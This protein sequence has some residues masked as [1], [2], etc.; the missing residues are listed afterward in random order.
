[1]HSDVSLFHICIDPLFDPLIILLPD[2]FLTTHIFILFN[3]VMSKNVLMQLLDSKSHILIE[4]S[5]DALK[6]F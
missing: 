3:S 1:M 2:A 4:P 5:H 6:I